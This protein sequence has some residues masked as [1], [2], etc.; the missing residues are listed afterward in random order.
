MVPYFIPTLLSI[1]FLVW[2]IV[3]F[4]KNIYRARALGV[5]V[6]SVPVSPMNV[7]WIVAEPMVFHILD[8]LPIDLGNFNYARR[9]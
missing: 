7:L 3:P 2:Y 5:P 1:L 8:R 6:L 9:G 4:A